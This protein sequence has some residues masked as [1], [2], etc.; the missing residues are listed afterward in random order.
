MATN[1]VM[2]QERCCRGKQRVGD[3]AWRLEAGRRAGQG[4]VTREGEREGM[5]LL[6]KRADLTRSGKENR[7]GN[8]CVKMLI[9]Q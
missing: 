7:C 8:F 4:W 3:G 2:Y 6:G 5:L 1:K 9:L